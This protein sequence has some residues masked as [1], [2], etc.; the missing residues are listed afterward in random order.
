MSGAAD[1]NGPLRVMELI[2]RLNVGG[3]ARLLA[4]LA[5]G[6]R[7]PEFNLLT[8]AGR[9]GPGETE[10]AWPEDLPLTRIEALTPVLGA[11]NR[12]ALAEISALLGEVRPAILHTHTAKAGT[13][14]RLAAMLRLK[15][16]GGRRLRLVHT[17]HGHVFSGYFSRM[18]SRLV[19]AV[20]R[21]LAALTDRVVV[22]SPEQAHD[23]CQVFG[24]CRPEKIVV[25]PN[26][27][28][29]APFAQARP[30]LLRRELGLEAE[31]PL[32][33]FVG[34][35]TAIK[36]PATILRA[37]AHIY[38]AHLALAGD[39][40]LR[41]DLQDLAAELGL[42]GR[43]HFLG[44]RSDMASFY[45]DLD[46]LVLASRNEGLPLVVLEALAAGRPVVSSLVGAVPSLLGAGE[47]PDP[48]RFALAQ[49]GLVCRPE[50]PTGLAAAMEW[51]IAHK[52]AALDLA[53]AGQAH[54]A[55]HHSRE[56]FVAAHAAL[57]RQLAGES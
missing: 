30:G 10:A 45:A 40:E 51:A 20:E 12:R 37:I 13:L 47:T 19:V 50:D 9:V 15:R 6:L 18:A 57:Y 55:S 16:I 7:P 49:R 42:A 32:V 41:Q 3:P 27:L 38:S 22:L 21:R 28:D 36:D 5:A 25:L 43:I 4:D 1:A 14:G 33:G 44:W 2:A 29:T 34:R 46:L 54:V 17:F 53:R 31:T 56:A 39:G 23:L 52:D 24:V 26:G 11:G 8:A 35:L 48:G